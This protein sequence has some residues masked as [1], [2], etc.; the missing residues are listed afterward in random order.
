MALAYIYIPY[1][2]LVIVVSGSMSCACSS[3]NY[4]VS[5]RAWRAICSTSSAAAAEDTCL[6]DSCAV[7]GQAQVCTTLPHCPA[8]IC[9][10][11]TNVMVGFQRLTTACCY[12]P[13]VVSTWASSIS[14]A[15][16]P[17]GA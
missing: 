12:F 14:S 16:R 2:R 15:L 4:S 7:C 9:A 5:A 13:E 10:V 6:L 3:A 17:R 11:A 1:T 8:A